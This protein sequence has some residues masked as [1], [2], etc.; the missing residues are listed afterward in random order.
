MNFLKKTIYLLTSSER[1][2]AGSIILMMMIMALLDATSV[3]SIMPLIAVISNPDIIQT[4]TFLKYLFDKS[5]MIGVENQQQFIFFFSSLVFVFLVMSL[6]FKAITTYVQLYFVQMREHSISKRL[7]ESYLYQPY[8][9]FLNHHSANLSKIILSEV[10]IVVNG[11]LKPIMTLLAQLFI[12]ITLSCLIFIVEPELSLIVCLILF[13]FYFSIYKFSSNFLIK[14]GKE[15]I[16]ANEERFATISEAFGAVKEIKLGNLEKSYVNNYSRPTRLFA[17]N[18]ASSFIISQIPRFALEAIVFGGM[19]FIIMFLIAKSEDFNSAV[20]LIALYA[21][22][23]YRLMPAFQQIYASLSQ[24]QFVS[25]ALE[26]VYKSLSMTKFNNNY[27]NKD[28]LTL[29]KKLILNKIYYKYP[30]ELRNTLSDLNLEITAR[31]TVG[32]IGV[33]GA[34]KTTLIDIIIGLLEPQKGTLEVDGKIINKNNY[35]SWQHLIGY[36]PQKIFLTDKSIAQNIAFG[37]D[38]EKIDYQAVER[39]AKI[40]NLHQFIIEQLPKKYETFVGEHGVR[41]SGGQRQR[42]GIARSLYRQ[43]QVLVFDEATNGLDSATEKKLLDEIYNLKESMTL[44]MISH[45]YDTL[46]KCDKIFKLEN[47]TVIEKSH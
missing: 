39:A 4:N 47:G 2:T 11:G 7:M 1:I 18:Q 19:I 25:P 20:P 24:L 8:E 33:S 35:H 16:K 40:A 32:L 6:A 42:I 41:L 27:K 36:V 9:W 45:Q 30:G 29:N 44:I 12:V 26:E 14:I 3:A 13:V 31:T 38:P 17:K 34:G 37:I 21:F 10:M 23:G 43:P 5:E 15:R 46:N 28:I 22:A